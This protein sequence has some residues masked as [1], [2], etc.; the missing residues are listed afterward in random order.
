MTEKPA[1]DLIDELRK[2]EE[3]AERALKSLAAGRSH[4]GTNAL[5]AIKYMARD[6][7]RHASE[8]VPNA[9]AADAATTRP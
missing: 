9:P 5:Q 6:A 8:P 1:I 7:V 3:R 4:N 2:I